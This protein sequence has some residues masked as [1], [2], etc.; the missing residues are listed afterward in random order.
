MMGDGDEARLRATYGDNYERLKAVKAVYDPSN[1]FSVNQ[2][3]PPA[4]R[5]TTGRP[6]PP[7]PCPAFCRH[8]GEA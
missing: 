2:N 4:T 1:F 6:V 7:A 8:R 3:I 5:D